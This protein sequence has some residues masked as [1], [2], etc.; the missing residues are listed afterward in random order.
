MV[1]AVPPDDQQSHHQ[2]VSGITVTGTFPSEEA[3]AAQ[4][5]RPL[6]PR[7]PR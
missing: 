1:V 2:L 6:M 7:R 5:V 3:K 4:V